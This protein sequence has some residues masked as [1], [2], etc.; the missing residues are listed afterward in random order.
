MYASYGLAAR[1]SRGRM[2]KTSVIFWRKPKR[3]LDDMILEYWH[4]DLIRHSIKMA[5]SLFIKQT[6]RQTYGR[7]IIG[8]RTQWIS[9]MLFLHCLLSLERLLV[10]CRVYFLGFSST[11]GF[12]YGR[13]TV[14]RGEWLTSSLPLSLHFYLIGA[15]FTYYVHR[16]VHFYFP[17]YI[18][19]GLQV[20][21]VSRAKH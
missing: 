14:Q 6:R 9:S 18:A 3:L 12:Q 16:N 17:L 13:R 5:V 19:L 4:V 1:N 15:V 7:F 2:T 8:R 11:F 20:P 21:P 10:A